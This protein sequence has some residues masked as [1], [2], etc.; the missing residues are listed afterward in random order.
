MRKGC[1]GGGS[2]GDGPEF[3]V[4]LSLSASGLSL[5][6]YF[7]GDICVFLDASE[8]PKHF[9]E[10]DGESIDLNPL[11]P[12]S[13]DELYWTLLHEAMHGLVRRDDGS[14]VSE[15]REHLMMVAVDPRLVADATA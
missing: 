9:A 11:K 6:P 12:W 4:S 5:A 10:T 2:A 14:E 7:R 1:T 13:R 15:L 3:G 8:R